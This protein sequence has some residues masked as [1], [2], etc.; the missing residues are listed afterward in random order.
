MRY[1]RAL[2]ACRAGEFQHAADL[3]QSLEAA[4]PNYPPLELLLGA[5][6][7]ASDLP[8]IA[9]AHL[10]RYGAEMPDDGAAQRLP[11]KAQGGMTDP[12][13]ASVS[14]Q[15]LLVAFG[16]PLSTGTGASGKDRF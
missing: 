4:L 14:P 1:Y 3:A 6:S 10:T 11:Q 7:L 13:A 8:A 5:A 2:L 9:A 12:M 15:E 16:F